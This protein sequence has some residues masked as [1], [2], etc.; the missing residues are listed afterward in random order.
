MGD[1]DVLDHTKHGHAWEVFIKNNI[2]HLQQLMFLLTVYAFSN[3]SFVIIMLLS[4]FFTA[5]F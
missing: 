4:S 3:E 2:D 1:A 5:N